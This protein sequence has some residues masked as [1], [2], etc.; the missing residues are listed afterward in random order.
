MGSPDYSAFS[1]A[2][3]LALEQACDDFEKDYRNGKSKPVREYIQSSNPQLMAIVAQEFEQIRLGENLIEN[4][5]VGNQGVSHTLVGEVASGKK[6]AEGTLIGSFRLIKPLGAGA[7]SQVWKAHHLELARDVAIKFPHAQSSGV[8]KRFARESQAVAKLRHSNIVSIHEVDLQDESNPF[9]VCDLVDGESLAEKQESHS[10]SIEETIELLIPIVDAVAYSHANGVVHRDLK[11]QNILI[12]ATGKPFVTD[13]GLARILNAET[14]L[15]THEGDILG[16]PAFMSPEQASGQ[17]NIDQRSD[18]YSL[19]VI[20][21]QLLTNELPFRGNIQS[22]VHQILTV[23]PPSPATLNRHVPKDLETICLKCLAKHPRQRFTQAKELLEELERFRD[24]KPILSRPISS[25]EKTKLWVARNKVVAGTL[26]VACLLLVGLGVGGVWFGLAMSAGKEREYRLRVAAQASEK[27]AITSKNEKEAALED[28]LF[29]KTI[30]EQKALD[31]ENAF[32]FLGSVF[33]ESEPVLSVLTGDGIGLGDPPSLEKMFRTASLRLRSRFPGDPK[34]QAKL[35]D[36]LGN[37][38]RSLGLYSI[39]QKLFDDSKQIRKS[40]SKAFSKTDFDFQTKENQFFAAQLLHDQGR[41][42]DALREYQ[43]CLELDALSTE[44]KL[45]RAT[46]QFQ[47]GRLYLTLRNNQAAKK[48]FASS[49][50]TR[51]LFLDQDSV[52]VRATQIGHEYCDCVAGNFESLKK[53]RKL[54]GRD[55]WPT[56]AA[57]KYLSMLISRNQNQL[58]TAVEKYRDLTIFLREHLS[59]SH[60]LFLTAMG[61][62]AGLLWDAGEYKDALPAV[63]FVIEK[64]QSIA[65]DHY[66]L[67]KAKLKLAVEL[68]RNGESELAV[69]IFEQLLATHENEKDIREIWHGLVW[70]YNAIGQPEKAKRIVDLLLIDLNQRTHEEATWILYTAARIYEKSDIRDFEDFDRRTKRNLKSRKGLPGSGF[71]SRRMAIVCIHYGE[72]SK[73]DE[74]I[75]HSLQVEAQRFPA[76]HPRIANCQMTLAT[77]LFLQKKYGAAEEQVRLALAIRKDRLPAESKMTKECESFLKRLKGLT[78]Q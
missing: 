4:T 27:E 32:Q 70:S 35:L 61:D 16:T 21:F 57:Q 26:G 53:I 49:L 75:R 10:F 62:F 41:L 54:I 52:V 64:A 74:L 63:Q 28:A 15:L 11:P 66:L 45:F 67:R 25:F 29:Q 14:E 38:C 51:K 23:D 34:T 47:M 60:P 7:T 72:L 46:V 69:P 9:L 73:A 13:F 12:D 8:L 56:K 59:E 40:N 68:H 78:K 3:L 43:S 37:S 33:K 6:L 5:Q 76:G 31:A 22:T 48:C 71:W 39:A 20:L 36:T 55:G 42:D 19:G 1:N 44:Q 24:G 77:V 2:E 17:A 65:G 30:A 18:V 58:G 50:E